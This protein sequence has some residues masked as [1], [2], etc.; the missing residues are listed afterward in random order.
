MLKPGGSFSDTQNTLSGQAL[1]AIFKMIKYLYKFTDMPINH[2]IDLYDKLISP[3]LNYGSEVWGF[4]KGSN[5]E[6]VL[7]QFLKRFLGVKRNTQSDFIYGE[8]GSTRYQTCRYY[9]IIK[10]WL[11]LFR[12]NDN[13][14]I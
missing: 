6:R 5:V 8:V 4:V 2:K 7:L 14:I 3:I 12:T 1:K 10:Y 11:K 13:T 9:N